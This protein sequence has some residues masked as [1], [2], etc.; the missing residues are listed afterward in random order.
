MKLKIHIN[1]YPYFIT[2]NYF[3]CINKLKQV[4]ASILVLSWV[5]CSEQSS[6]EQ[7]DKKTKVLPKP[8]INVFLE[9]SGSM[10]GYVK[11]VTQFEQ[12]IYNYLSDL[13]NYEIADS[14]NLFY[15]NSQLI[16]QKLSVK[17]FIQD[18][19]PEVFVARGGNR[20][21]TDIAKVLAT[22]LNNTDSNQVSIFVTDGIF[23]PG[24]GVNA[25]E[26]LANQEIEI[27]NHWIAY[28]KKH[29]QT[30]LVLYKLESQFEGTYYDREDKPSFIRTQR[31][32]YLWIFGNSFYMQQI[33]KKIPQKTSL[34]AD[35][36]QSLCLYNQPYPVPY[37]IMRNSGEFDLDDENPKKAIKNLNKIE[38]GN[39]K[40]AK[41]S[42]KVNLDT[43]ML[44]ES[45]I[46]DST[47]Y[48]CNEKDFKYQISKLVEPLPGFSHQITFQTEKDFTGELKLELKKNIP[49]WAQTA[50]DSTGLQPVPHKT[51]GILHQL[52]ALQQAF[53]ITHDYFTEISITV[54]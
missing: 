39:K 42:V 43:L 46:L 53:S 17:E 30:M 8:V 45:Y 6:E 29:P 51:F 21:A 3:F 2:V 50:H 47:N 19:E 10:D 16:P 9:N 5:A 25:Q 22:V 41:F 20:Q 54:K 1:L 15:V 13:K 26:Y 23:S 32:Y 11:G 52:I 24:K 49:T 33:L 38:L 31:P 48:V 14:F 34:R 28:L 4:L 12:A 40:I 7:N 37:A 18:L 36:L 27:K 44:P 35:S